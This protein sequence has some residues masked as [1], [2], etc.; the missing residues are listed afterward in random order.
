MDNTTSA[1]Q[2]IGSNSYYYVHMAYNSQNREACMRE[3]CEFNVR[4]SQFKILWA[5]E[6]PMIRD[7]WTASMAVHRVKNH[8]INGKLEHFQWKTYTPICH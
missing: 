2:R 8:G 1:A 6:Q 7:W 4:G 5:T 3:R